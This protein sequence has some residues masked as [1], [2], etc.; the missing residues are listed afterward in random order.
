MF[1]TGALDRPTGYRLRLCLVALK[2]CPGGS[3]GYSAKNFVL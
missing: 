3:F 1:R 2:L